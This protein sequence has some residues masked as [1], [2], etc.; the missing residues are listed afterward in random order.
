MFKYCLDDVSVYPSSVLFL[1]LYG[2]SG[3]KLCRQAAHLWG[4]TSSSPHVSAS[5]TLVHL[6]TF[7]LH[8]RLS[9]RPNDNH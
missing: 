7:K 6:I 8:R 9:A 2:F 5:A 1:V 3:V 4:S